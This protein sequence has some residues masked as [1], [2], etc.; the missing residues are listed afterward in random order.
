MNACYMSA[1]DVE[2]EVFGHESAEGGHGLHVGEVATL[3][4]LLHPFVE[5]IVRGHEVGDE[6]EDGFF[7]GFQRVFG[8]FSGGELVEC[9]GIVEDGEH[10]LGAERSHGVGDAVDFDGELAESLASVDV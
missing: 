1:F 3:F 8:H 5:S 9:F 6:W 7:R 10:V 2:G 4:G